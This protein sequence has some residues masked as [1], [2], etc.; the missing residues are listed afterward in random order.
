[1]MG[2]MN[3]TALHFFNRD[4]QAGI[5]GR[6]SAHA[7]RDGF[8]GMRAQRRTRAH[9]RIGVP[10]RPSA[11]TQAHPRTQGQPQASVAARIAMHVAL[12][13]ASRA[14]S[15]IASRTA[16]RQRAP[17]QFTHPHHAA[18]ASPASER[19]ASRRA[20]AACDATRRERI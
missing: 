13:P 11:D 2:D 20:V 7:M 10:A 4:T 5:A 19:R 6:A 18:A 9:V 14:P 15:C 8:A 1:M 16:S 17:K 3:A 12:H